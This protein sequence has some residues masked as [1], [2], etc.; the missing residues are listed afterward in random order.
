MP[1]KVKWT[2][3][4]NSILRTDHYAII[5]EICDDSLNGTSK[6]QTGVIGEITSACPLNI[7]QRISN[8][9]I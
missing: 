8:C 1:F 3:N 4:I 7:D 9:K 5:I 2:T 6:I